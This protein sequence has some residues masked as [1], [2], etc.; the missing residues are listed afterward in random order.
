[1]SKKVVINDIFEEIDERLITQG[2]PIKFRYMEAV[3]EVSAYF[4]NVPIPLSPKSPLPDNEMGNQ[5]CVWLHDWYDA[6]YGKLQSFNSDL[7]F[8]YQK[9]RGDL[10]HYRVPNFVGTCN[11]FIDKNL[12]VCG[13]HNETNIMRMSSNMTQAY[14]NS[15]T[16]AELISLMASFS[17]ALESFEIL[18]GWRIA[19]IPLC[20]AIEADLKTI[21]VQ[22]QTNTMNY[23]QARWAYSQCAE[24]ILKAWLLK[25][26]VSEKRLKDKYGHSI[27]KLV[28]AFN[29]H[30]NEQLSSDKFD[31]ITCSPSARYDEDDF[32]SEDIIEAQNWLFETIKTIG[33]SPKLATI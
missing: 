13:A 25:A 3:G 21:T 33:F 17:S 28:N 10:W 15:L 27:H 32:S 18:S 4:G 5:L 7:G 6:K 29:K 22:L 12:T 19:K 8:F 20:Q 2:V 31:A 11:F 30:Y 26:G 23:G 24:K 1:M 9:I 14:V 16:D